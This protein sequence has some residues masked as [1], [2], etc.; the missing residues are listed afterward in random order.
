MAYYQRFAFFHHLD[1]PAL[2]GNGARPAPV[3]KV[4]GAFQREALASRER[5]VAPIGGKLAAN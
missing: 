1:G 5:K 2:D 3:V 4:A